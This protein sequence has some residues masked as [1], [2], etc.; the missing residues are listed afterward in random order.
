MLGWMAFLIVLGPLHLH[1]LL[2]MHKMGLT[3]RFRTK[4]TLM[5]DLSP[6]NHTPYHGDSMPEFNAAS[7]LE[8]PSIFLHG[9]TPEQISSRSQIYRVAYE[10]ARETVTRKA[11]DRQWLETN[12]LTFGDGI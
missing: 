12:G 8:I 3:I 1:L 11:I 9:M 4:G 5:S 2:L 6:E 10:K 7:F